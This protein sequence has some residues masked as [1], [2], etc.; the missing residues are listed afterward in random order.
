MKHYE[1]Q[2]FSPM[3]AVK[4]Y[5]EAEA[6]ADQAETWADADYG[7]KGKLS[8]EERIQR[9]NADLAAAQVHATLALAGAT[10]LN[11]ASGDGMPGADWKAWYDAAGAR[12]SYGPTPPQGSASR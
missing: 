11:R 5:L 4:H 10:A 3:N 2:G 9:R 1:E 7:W 6:L 12:Q 8:A